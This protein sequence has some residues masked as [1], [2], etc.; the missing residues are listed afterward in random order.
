VEV[1]SE[2]SGRL[3]QVLVDVNDRVSRGQILAVINTDIIGDQ[4]IQ[5]RSALNS[6]RA[7][8]QAAQA[9]LDGDEAQLSRLVEVRRLSQGRT[10]SAAEVDQA[11]AAV[12]RGKALLAASRASVASAAAQLSTAETQRSR[13]VIRSPVSGVVLARQIEPGQTVAANFSTPTLFVLAEDLA[14]M[15]LRVNVDEADVGQVQIG[16]QATFTVDAYPGRQF[17]ARVERVDVASNSVAASDRSA[18]GQQVVSYEARLQVANAEGLLRPGMT[19]SVTIE[20][21][22]TGARMVVPNGALRFEP[23]LSDEEDV[24]L[25]DAEVD[26]TEDD[27]GSIGVGS[28]Q[29]VYTIDEGGILKEHRVVTGQTNGRFT[30]VRGATLR[31]GMKIVTGTRS[32]NQND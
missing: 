28:R 9:T 25:F 21:R 3:D 13:A 2:I 32:S 27:G 7:D 24:G 26:A 12:N 4:I 29:T 6:A 15:Q 16:Q 20:T 23:D 30:V 8:V 19:A 18:A 10:P 22:S 31:E 5:G 1:G 17:P 11:R 14:I